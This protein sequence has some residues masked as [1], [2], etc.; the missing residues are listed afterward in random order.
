MSSNKVLFEYS[1]PPELWAALRKGA[2]FYLNETGAAWNWSAVTFEARHLFSLFIDTSRPNSSLA[3]E[4]S[5]E[6]ARAAAECGALLAGARASQRGHHR[7]RD[8]VLRESKY[9]EREGHHGVCLLVLLHCSL[10]WVVLPTLWR[11]FGILSQFRS[12][13]PWNYDTL[14]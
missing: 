14:L 7:V 2:F 4:R 8:Q 3:G 5:H 11:H 9:Q 6:G 13:S 10:K 1:L 12:L